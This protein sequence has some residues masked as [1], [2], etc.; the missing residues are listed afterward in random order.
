MKILLFILALIP[1]SVTGQFYFDFE[2]G[3][4]EG[5]VFNNPGRWECSSDQ[6]LSGERSLHHIYD[7]SESG[8]DIAAIPVDEL[9]ASLGDV[10]WRFTIRHGSDPSSSNNWGLFLAAD[11]DVELLCP[12]E[13][14]SGFLAG[15]NMTGYD[16]TLRL[17][18][19]VRGTLTPVITTSV[20][21]QA[22][23]GTEGVAT[24]VVTR[25]AEG[26]W[27]LMVTIDG[28][29]SVFTGYGE[30]TD[31]FDVSLLGLCYRYTSTRD[32]LLWLDNLSVEGVFIADS[33]PPLLKDVWFESSV[34]LVILTDEPL[35]GVSLQPENYLLGDPWVYPGAVEAAG[36]VTR[37]L[38]NYSFDNRVSHNL[39]IGS[40]CDQKGNCSGEYDTLITLSMPEWGDIVITELMPDPEPV[41][42]L[43]PCEYIEIYNCS[44][45][46]FRD[47]HL[48]LIIGLGITPIYIDNFTPGEYIVIP[49]SGCQWDDTSGIRVTDMAFQ[50]AL[51]NSGTSVILTDGDGNT[52]HGVTY[53]SGWFND[54]LKEEGGWSLEMKDF[55]YPFQDGVNWSYSVSP[56]GGT[57]GIINSVNSYNPDN[58]KPR[59]EA[60]YVLSDTSLSI[61]FSEPVETGK[62]LPG[63][64]DLAI[65]AAGNQKA[66]LIRP[67][68]KRGKSEGEWGRI[69]SVEEA[70]R[71]RKEFILTCNPP[72]QHDELYNLT[73]PAD[74]SDF[75]GNP[76]EWRQ[77]GT[78]FASLPDQG[79]I[80]INEI[81][82]D[83]LPGEAE[84]I[85]LYNN[86]A[87]VVDPAAL[88]IS[89]VNEQSGDT[90]KPVWL[91]TVHRSLMPGAYYAITTDRNS[92]LS[93]YPASG[94][95]TV[96]ETGALPSLPDGGGALLLFSRNCNLTDRVSYNADMHSDILSGLS[97]ISLEK[98]FPSAPSLANSSWHS[99]AGTAGWGTPG[100]INSVFMDHPAEGGEIILSST[101]LSPDNDGFEDILQI[102]VMSELPDVIIGCTIF[103][104]RG[105]LLRR[106][107]RNL[108]GTGRDILYWDGKDE[109][110]KT[111]ERGLYI[112]YFN[113]SGMD[114]RTSRFR[115]VVSVIR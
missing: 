35:S 48:S 27:E 89:S 88:F 75:G 83:P 68:L 80:V 43:P 99:A 85:E 26:Y 5:W 94:K 111:V 42:D 98:I 95:S 91:S 90:G 102:T 58:I 44:E 53:N 39:V 78:G 113:L 34:S 29:D 6:P 64:W 110:G 38:F 23:I 106:L 81:L 101:R 108:P 52:L 92:V 49:G 47:L 107:A 65:T 50:G 3:T 21:W 103:S 41:V 8:T 36:N 77:M 30:S 22:D 57:P 4:T 66:G 24:I 54:K 71:L 86:S 105:I 45:Y 69:T 1:L 15:V 60:L 16:D 9:Q 7:N 67:S 73:I 2:T 112:L 79:D 59:P 100:I 96:F 33:D 46:H 109:N 32:R 74:I 70:D 55:N 31:W 115:K 61:L 10:I 17:W 11:A 114:G 63:E 19:C 18:K 72:L 14:V 20:N 13:E 97:G 76:P 12:G 87:L 56:R 93:C 28:E 84:Y 104:D 82:F 40:L 62:A 51:V 25:S 37:L